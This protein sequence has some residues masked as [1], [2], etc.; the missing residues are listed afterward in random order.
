VML[1]EILTGTLP[2]DEAPWQYAGRE[3]GGEVER[4]SLSYFLSYPP[5]RSLNPNT[6]EVLERITYRCLTVME[7]GLEE[8]EADLVDFLRKE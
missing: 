8:L 2:F 3:H 1:Y 6:P 5:P 7:Y 4:L